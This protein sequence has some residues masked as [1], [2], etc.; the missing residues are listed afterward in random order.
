M[1]ELSDSFYKNVCESIPILC[2]D[3]LIELNNKFLLI[4]R[5]QE[6]LKNHFWVP[7]G[8]VFHKEKIEDA[9]FRICLREIGIDIKNINCE[10]SIFGFTETIYPF[11]RVS[12]SPYHTP[13]IV[14]RV[15]IKQQ[16][17]II[18]DSTS[19]EYLWSDKIPK[20]LLKELKKLKSI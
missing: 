11:S 9:L 17:E 12:K 15:K 3:A 2:V 1:K 10:Y 16:I 7:G 4:K 18:L 8:R 13:A 19:S 20:I 14:F 5:N 6:P